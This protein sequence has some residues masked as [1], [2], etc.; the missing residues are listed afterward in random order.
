MFTL[1]TAV[2]LLL[3]LSTVPPHSSNTIFDDL[4]SS[5]A[6]IKHK[7]PH[8]QIILGGDFNCPGRTIP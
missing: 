4:H 3:A 7:H 2:V 5:I 1:T 6:M 8:T